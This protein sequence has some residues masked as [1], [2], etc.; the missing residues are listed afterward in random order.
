MARDSLYYT[1]YTKLFFAEKKVEIATAVSALAALNSA[2]IV[3]TIN[4]FDFNGIVIPAEKHFRYIQ[5]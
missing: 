5:I 4:L 3:S 1:D 2:E